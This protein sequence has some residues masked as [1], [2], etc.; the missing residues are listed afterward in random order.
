MLPILDAMESP[1]LP[2]SYLVCQNELR[3]QIDAHEWPWD[4]GQF[5]LAEDSS[6][7]KNIGTPDYLRITFGLCSEV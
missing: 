3:D 2:P 1:S 7:L 6:F 5:S 4:Q